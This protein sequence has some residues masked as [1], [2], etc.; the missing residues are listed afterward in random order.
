MIGLAD[1][2]IF[3]GCF[4]AVLLLF[5]AHLRTLIEGAQP[6]LFDRRD[7][8]EYV[9]AAVVGLNKSKSLGRVEPLYGTCCHFLSP[10]CKYAAALYGSR[11]GSRKQKP[12]G[13][14]RLQGFLPDICRPSGRYRAASQCVETI[15]DAAKQHPRSRLCEL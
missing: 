15:T 11:A 5:V 4:P 14:G 6:G 13:L 7:V 3:R 10:F 2:E 8:Y 12:P 1:P 9:F